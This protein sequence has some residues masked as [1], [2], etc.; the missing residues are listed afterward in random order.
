MTQYEIK[1]LMVLGF[2]TLDLLLKNN[3]LK[4]KT[5]YGVFIIDKPFG[6]PVIKIEFMGDTTKEVENGCG[7]EL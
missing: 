7:E 6:A 3:Q 1:K 2:S 5:P 4:I